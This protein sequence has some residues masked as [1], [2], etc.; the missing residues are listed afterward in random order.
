MWQAFFKEVGANIVVSGATNQAMVAAGAA[1]MVSDTCLPMKVFA[2]HVLSLIG[3]CDYLLVPVVRSTAHKVYN[4]SRFLGLPDVIRAVV[5]ETPPIIE[6]E[7]D[8]NR[9]RRF[10]YRQIYEAGRH[11][12]RNPLR[13][14]DAA[15]RAWNT[16]R[17]YLDIMQERRLTRVEAIE[18][19]RNPAGFREPAVPAGKNGLTIG[20]VGHPYVM[21]DEQVSHRLIQRLRED[22][23]TVLTP[24]MFPGEGI[25]S[26]GQYWEAEADVIGSGDHFIRQKV[27]GIIGIMAFSCGPD[28][29]MMHLVQRQAQQSGIPFM[30]LTVEEH[31]AEAG[32][33]TR[34][35]AFMDMIYRG[36]R[37]AGL[38]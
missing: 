7:F 37:K 22:N 34:L 19:M 9:G 30:S 16:Y 35:E 10:L 38:T 29:L 12:T 1:R 18:A 15:V 11:F 21:Y 13:I 3:K 2:G 36:R 24:G 5:P 31:A 6:P 4:C 32:I 33:I 8:I 25:E 27:D 23:I 20:L 14:R 28:S 17:R 26:P